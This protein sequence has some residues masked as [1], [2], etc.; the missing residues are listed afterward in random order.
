MNFKH[1]VTLNDVI[2]F[3]DTWLDG[4][5]IDEYDD[6]E[7]FYDAYDVATAYEDRPADFSKEDERELV[8]RAYEAM[9]KK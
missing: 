4:E 9:T 1:E 7:A 2:R 5:G 6:F 8:R 3:I